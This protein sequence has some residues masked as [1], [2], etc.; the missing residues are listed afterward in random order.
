MVMLALLGSLIGFVG[1]GA[2]I[3]LLV[4]KIRKAIDKELDKEIEELRRKN[5]IQDNK[6]HKED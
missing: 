1:A 6:E 5:K 3:T 2:I 4:I